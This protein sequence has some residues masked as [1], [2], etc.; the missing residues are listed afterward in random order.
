[1]G[2][3]EA[4]VRLE[5]VNEQLEQAN[6]AL[7]HDA[8]HDPLTEL[9]NRALFMDRL[10][11]MLQ[12]SS[13]D[14]AIGCAVLFIDLDGFKLVNDSLS[15]SIGDQ[16]LVAVARRFRDVLRPGDTVA[17]I[18]GD[19]FALLLDGVVIERDA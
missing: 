16:L 19:E 3:R 2:L 14:A 4:N 11:Q 7:A 8:L 1:T 6:E 12:R 15:H 9:A 10:E 5:A 13:R 18:G 17:R